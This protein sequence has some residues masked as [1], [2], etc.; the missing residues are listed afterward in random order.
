MSVT[1]NVNS[2]NSVQMHWKVKE[3]FEILESDKLI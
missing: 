2:S 3:V 1:Y